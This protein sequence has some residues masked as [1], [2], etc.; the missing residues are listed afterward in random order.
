M[1]ES[2]CG[3]P[4]FPGALGLELKARNGSQPPFTVSLALRQA[5]CSSQAVYTSARL[6]QRVKVGL[7]WQ[8]EWRPRE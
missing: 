3:L 6:N 2:A 1:E 8:W 7:S 4:Q 5:V